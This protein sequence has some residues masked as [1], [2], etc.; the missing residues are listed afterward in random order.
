MHEQQMGSLQQQVIDSEEEEE[1]KKAPM[2]R[3]IEESTPLKDYDMYLA[4]AGGARE[5]SDDEDE[6]EFYQ[7]SNPVEVIDH[8][9][10][11]YNGGDGGMWTPSKQYSV[12][13]EEEEGEDYGDEDSEGK[14]GP[15]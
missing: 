2:D 5:C 7:R 14:A 12:S 6:P 3:D 13:S 4:M 10:H 15:Q 9:Q 11:D 8:H 1:E